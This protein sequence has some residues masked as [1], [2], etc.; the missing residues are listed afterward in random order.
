M[1]FLLRR[2]HAA[3]PYLLLAPGI[4]W[5]VLFF[6]V[7]LYYMAQISLKEGSIDTGYRFTWHFQTY[8]DAISNY[9]DQF[10]RSFE[11]A[12]LATVLSLVIAYPL[13]YVIAFR[14]GRWRNALLLLV[15][16]PFFTT[17]LVRTLSW[18]T[19]LDDDGWIVHVL[20]SVG[21]LG[22]HGRLLATGTAVVTGITYNFL[23]FMIL[24][25]YA[26]LERI[27]KRLHEAAYD[28]YGRRRDV[29]LRVTLPLSAP[30]IV[31]GVLLTF[32]PA[33]GDFVNAQLLGT[34]RQ[35]M[36][37]NVIQSR[38][39]EVTDYPTAAALSFILMAI[40]LVLVLAYAKIAGTE[41]LTGA[42][43]VAA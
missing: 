8:V 1:A 33:A 28:L 9:S 22:H 37:G 5:L 35:S 17:Y 14:G 25:L 34:P 13:A 12:G 19:I 20:Q 29:F 23:P 18:E 3:A 36:I 27:D 2:R 26:S 11:Y 38:Y 42:E 6:A 39:L 15:I 16:L 21:L 10:L 4:G 24:P 43:G 31:A 7:P 41:E 32:I 30:G 40:I